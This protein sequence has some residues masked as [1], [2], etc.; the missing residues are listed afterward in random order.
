MEACSSIV[1]NSLTLSTCL[2]NSIS[3]APAALNWRPT[4]GD[5]LDKN[6]CFR[7]RTGVSFM[8]LHSKAW[9]KSHFSLCKQSEG[10]SSVSF[11]GSEKHP[12]T[13]AQW[14]AAC[15]LTCLLLSSL[16][17]SSSSSN[18]TRSATPSSRIGSVVLP[19]F[20]A[21]NLKLSQPLVVISAGKCFQRTYV[22]WRSAI[23]CYQCDNSIRSIIKNR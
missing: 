8:S 19:I 5:K 6:W 21:T 1:I 11:Y 16:W 22:M 10:D 2:S 4:L 9:A 20:P 14:A 18:H 7:I 23:L 17:S 15:W 13:Q 12:R 3:V